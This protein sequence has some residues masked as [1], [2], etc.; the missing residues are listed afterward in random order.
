MPILPLEPECTMVANHAKPCMRR[1]EKRDVVELKDYIRVI[2]KRWQIIVAVML[3]VLAGAAL[4]TALSP[5]VYQAQTQL[6]VSTSGGSDT[7]ALLSVS[8][9]SPQRIKPYINVITTPKVLDSVIE[10]LQLKTTAAKLGDE[11]TATVP[12]DTVVIA[13]DVTNADPRVAAQIADADRK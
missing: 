6:F 3:V 7:S 2:R 10:A 13:V 8:H 5:N 1:P 4:A 12:L 9:F 11:I